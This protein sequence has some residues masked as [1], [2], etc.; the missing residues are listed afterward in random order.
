MPR[1]ILRWEPEYD[2]EILSIITSASDYR[3]CWYLNQCLHFDLEFYEALE[4]YL[5]SKKKTFLFDRFRYYDEINKLEYYLIT[6]QS[7]GGM[8]LSELKNVDYIL[9]IQGGIAHDMKTEIWAAIKKI[10]II[11]AVFDTPVF[12]LKN[13]NRL[14]F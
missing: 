2:F 12:E 9:K 5:P 7:E 4:I 1:N 6:N 14:L 8:L 10:P 13:K 3:L 11:E